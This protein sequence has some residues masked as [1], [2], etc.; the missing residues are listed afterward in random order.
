MWTNNT[1]NLRAYI[2]NYIQDITNETQRSRNNL[3]N[4]NDFKNDK[5]CN[6]QSSNTQHLS[7]QGKR[8]TNIS[9]N[10]LS[11]LNSLECSDNQQD[12]YDDLVT[13]LFVTNGQLN[14]ISTAIAENV[15]SDITKK[16][17][18]D[19]CQ[20]CR[21]DSTICTI[22]N[23][24]SIDG[25]MYSDTFDTVYKESLKFELRGD[26]DRYL[27]EISVAYSRYIKRMLSNFRS[28]IIGNS[29]SSD[30][31]IISR[32]SLFKKLII[33][34]ESNFNVR[35]VKLKIYYLIRHHAR[36]IFS[37]DSIC[38]DNMFH[39]IEMV[40]D[41]FEGCKELVLLDY[42]EKA[43]EEFKLSHDYISDQLSPIMNNLPIVDYTMYGYSI[44]SG[45]CL[46]ARI[47][48]LPNASY[49]KTL[50]RIESLKLIQEYNLTVEN[51]TELITLQAVLNM[52]Y[53]LSYQSR[54]LNPNTQPHSIYLSKQSISSDQ[55]YSNFSDAI[56][57]S[58]LS[59]CGTKMTIVDTVGWQF[60]RFI[61]LHYDSLICNF[62]AGKLLVDTELD[63]SLNLYPLIYS[64]L[65]LVYFEMTGVLCRESS[66]MYAKF[67]TNGA[68][69][70]LSNY[71]LQYKSDFRALL[72]FHF[73]FKSKLVTFPFGTSGQTMPAN[74]IEHNNEIWGRDERQSLA[75]V[76]ESL[77]D[78]MRAAHYRL[79]AITSKS[80]ALSLQ[81]SQSDL[82]Y[83][84]QH[85][86][87]LRY[88]I[89]QYNTIS[90]SGIYHNTSLVAEMAK[91]VGT[92]ITGKTD[93]PLRLR[94][95]RM[96][97]IDGEFVP[98]MF[99][100]DDMAQNGFYRKLK[101]Y[102]MTNFEPDVLAYYNNVND[103]E[104]KFLQVLTNKSGGMKS[105]TV[106]LPE[107]LHG[108]SNARLI[109]FALDRELYYNRATFID[110][111]ALTKICGI[112]F[113]IDRRARIIVVVPNA[114]QTS[115]SQLLIGFNAFKKHCKNIAVGKQV[116]NITDAFYQMHHSGK[117]DSIM[118]NGDMAGQDAHT[119]T[120]IANF[121]RSLFLSSLLKTKYDKAY[122][123]AQSTE[124]T[125]YDANCNQV[126]T[127]FIPSVAIHMANVMHIMNT[128]EVAIKDKYF[129]FGNVPTNRETYPSG[130]FG[131]SLTHTLM[132]TMIVNVALQDFNEQRQ[133]SAG[134]INLSCVNRVLGDDI[135]QV[136][137]TTDDE[138]ALDWMQYLDATFRSTNFEQDVSI[139]RIY[140]TF[141]QQTAVCGRY[142]PLPARTSIFCD[143]KDETAKRD[144]ID[145]MKI[146]VDV[147]N[148]AGQRTYSP[149][150]SLGFIRS[151]WNSLRIRRYSS[152]NSISIKDKHFMT[153]IP[154]SVIVVNPFVTIFLPPIST[155]WIRIRNEFDEY[156]PNTSLTQFGG[157]SGDLLLFNL[158][159]S[160]TKKWFHE[161]YAH[162]YCSSLIDHMNTERMSKFGILLADYLLQ[163]KRSSK[164]ADHR[165]E[166][167][168]K[169]QIS[170]MIQ[171]LDSHLD[172]KKV[173]DCFKA[174]VALS[175]GG[176]KIPENLSY[177]KQNVAKIRQSLEVRIEN[178]EER[179][180]LDNVYVSYINKFNPQSIL[181][182]VNKRMNLSCFYFLF[183]P[184]SDPLKNKQ[185]VAQGFL[186]D[187][188]MMCPI[189]PS[190]NKFSS[191]HYL[192]SQLG[193]VC[194][195]GSGT[196]HKLGAITETM[197]ASFN[198][199]AAIEFGVNVLAS[200]DG[201]NLILVV[202]D[203][204]GIPS[205]LHA[206]Y[207]ALVTKYSQEMLNEK[208]LSILL[209]SK[210]FAVSGTLP[211]SSYSLN[212]LVDSSPKFGNSN[213]YLKYLSVIIRD[214]CSIFPKLMTKSL[215]LLDP[216]INFEIATLMTIKSNTKTKI[217]KKLRSMQE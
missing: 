139:S 74:L 53:D 131:T 217:L 63:V 202:P 197:G 116:G 189:L 85:V 182:E 133:L 92:K 33:Y 27:N 68:T 102:Y 185:F 12:E 143:E 1:D 2:N 66:L 163:F 144:P 21:V 129:K 78:H 193:Y 159:I 156:L 20:N 84:F 118:N 215:F 22:I 166:E 198:I 168:G 122:F 83:A 140:A 75:K 100:V 99:N 61:Y 29:T 86:E 69:T 164:L 151:I 183:S 91:S 46:D 28:Y 31:N 96:V 88:L 40:S 212:K 6:Y 208:Y 8:N 213:V 120:S 209:K 81:A 38:T 87:W 124:Y 211:T 154:G 101:E 179:D 132:L 187:Q 142:V 24:I 137:Q 157:N 165:E 59:T 17:C 134:N 152:R 175:Q 82:K 19:H 184:S 34:W 26:V 95:T 10:I 126:G 36:E 210:Y 176:I 148:T 181:Q 158:F 3:T 112:R 72:K 90:N 191:F 89:I 127:A 111:C 174:E 194:D 55:Y 207:L 110:M 107:K 186:R 76:L 35:L 149:D 160:K 5:A 119:I 60:L 169:R 204:L 44:A 114:I 30:S 47:R 45:Q 73:D 177:R 141:L 136:I 180:Y 80:A 51:K 138:L 205:M 121:I 170:I 135:F 150:N 201:P 172:T 58:F 105:M 9:T 216:L 103:Y 155:P 16:I 125:L 48:Y 42:I 147:I 39:C 161:N 11:I 171:N 173:S 37:N 153:D 203:L 65:N 104:A 145:C 117:Y 18:T 49:R 25:S 106:G 4:T 15:V 77:P 167:I 214:A 14:S 123:W 67:M 195:S 79:M 108:I 192:S 54:F 70:S 162:G 109:Q 32:I 199:E 93:V 130:L 57:T 190:Y 43:K 23:S 115:E 128:S 13:P 196:S 146:L 62:R 50:A 71:Q 94:T 64:L 206:E 200:D 41:A 113:Q 178:L 7:I 188:E 56:K 52:F 98:L 97:K